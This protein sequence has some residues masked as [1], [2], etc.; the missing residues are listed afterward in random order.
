MCYKLNRIIN[1]LELE[2]VN[3]CYKIKSYDYI[4]CCKG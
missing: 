4:F 3:Y 1:K 2:Y